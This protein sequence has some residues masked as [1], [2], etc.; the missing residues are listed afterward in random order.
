MRTVLEE[1]SI[2]Q[3]FALRCG[4]Q[5]VA[6]G[7]PSAKTEK[8]AQLELLVQE[9]DMKNCPYPDIV[10]EC[11]YATLE[12]QGVPRDR[13]A[14]RHHFNFLGLLLRMLL[15]MCSLLL[16]QK[17]WSLLLRQNLWLLLFVNG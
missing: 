10:V 8:N 6:K 14:L 1:A 2:S 5:A 16:L 12:A 15:P 9:L 11:M 17:L 4:R 3:L 13:I 7:R